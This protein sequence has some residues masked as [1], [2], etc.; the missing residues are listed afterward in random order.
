MIEQCISEENSLCLGKEEE[1]KLLKIIFWSF[2]IVTKIMIFDYTEK[3]KYGN[4]NLQLREGKVRVQQ[5]QILIS[6]VQPESANL[7]FSKPCIILDSD[8]M[9][10]KSIFREKLKEQHQK[11]EERKCGT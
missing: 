6:N 1:I 5:P 9:N 2:E 7:D 10:Q 11:N 8:L 3:G 4:E